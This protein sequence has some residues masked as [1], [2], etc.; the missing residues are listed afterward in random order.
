[1]SADFTALAQLDQIADSAAALT[2]PRRLALLHQRE[3][4]SIQHFLNFLE[5]AEP[6]AGSASCGMTRRLICWIANTGSCFLLQQPLHPTALLM[7]DQMMQSL[8]CLTGA[9]TREPSAAPPAA[10]RCPRGCSSCFWS[11]SAATMLP[12]TMLLSG[13]DRKPARPTARMA[14]SALACT[15]PA[16]M[17]TSGLAYK[18]RAERSLSCPG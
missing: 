14:A 6:V 9:R 10:L 7:K 12:L 3:Y 8:C 15:S 11:A 17:F 1:M 13:I 5:Q 18:N 16:D 2:Q 4:K